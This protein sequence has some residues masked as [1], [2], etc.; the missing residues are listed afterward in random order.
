MKRHL[1]ARFA[2]LVICLLLLLPQ[3]LLFSSCSKAEENMIFAEKNDFSGKH[4][5]IMTGSIFDDIVDSAIDGVQYKN[6]MDI[7]GHIAALKKRDV[8]AIALDMPV[9]KLLVA[10]NPEFAIFPQVIADDQYGL[11][12]QKNSPLTQ[13]FTEAIQAFE[14]DGTIKALNDKWFSGDSEKMKIDW[15][16]YQLTNRKNGTLRYFYENT[17]MPMGYV[18]DGGKPAG[19]EV[20]LVLKI[21]DRLDMGVTFGSTT[22][23]ALINNLQA[24]KADVCSG[25]V[26]ITEERAKSVD[27]PVTHYKGGSVLVC[28]VEN[29]PPTDQAGVTNQSFF[30]GIANSIKGTFVTENRWKLIANGLLITLVITVFAGIIGTVLGFGL[31]LILRSRHKWLAKLGRGFCRL[32]TGVPSL[33]FLMIVYFVMFAASSLSPVV[34][35]ILA[36][37]VMFAVSVS[38]IFQTGIDAVDHG[39]WE[40]TAALGFGKTGSFAK[41]IMPQAMR[42]I[43][44]IYKGEFVSMLKLTSIVGYISI[45]DLTKAGDLIRSRTYEAFFP[46]IT[47]A[48]IYFII[49]WI[50]TCIIGRAEITFDPAKRKK[51]LL[52]GVVTDH[53]SQ[54]PAAHP[55]AINREPLIEIAH[56][57][58]EYELATPLTDVNTTVQRGDVI[59]IIGPSGTGKS[60]LLRC[61]NRLETPTSGQVKVFGQDIGDKKTDLN[62]VRQ[63]MGMVFQ[64]FN[65]FGHLTVIENLMLAPVCLKKMPRQE[66]Y[67]RGM[68]LLRMVGMAERAMQYPSALSGGQKQRVAIARALAMSPEVLLLDEPTSALDP[69]MVSEVLSVIKQLSAEHYTMVIVT[70]EMKFAKDVSNR[71]FYMDEGIIYE[72]GAPD[73][74]FENPL[75]EK[76][77]AFVK[78]LRSLN[79]EINSKDFDLYDLN[80]KLEEFA[81]RHFLTQAQL[82]NLQLVL[83]ELILNVILPHSQEISLRVGY[84]ETDGKLELKLTFGGDAL[85]PFALSDTD[86][87]AMMLV[88]KHAKDVAY[89]YNQGNSLAFT[90]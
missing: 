70:H 90:L 77:K 72:D 6:Y 39:Q 89:Q 55:A 44:P 37:S 13:P 87:L 11:V 9:A 19:Y 60:T 17:T 28:R 58:K 14:Q 4:V 73:Q 5:G 29:L 66:A 86:E 45:D 18:G 43:L 67:D 88:R 38:G 30:A 1:F 78:R 35:A 47:T 22:L 49:A 50:F 85:N 2:C 65:L 84:Y 63:R 61:M 40:A 36:F 74:V 64:S 41:V 79:Y 26:S 75:K 20:E 16:A 46:L 23:A 34:V 48:I 57:R 69:T 27:F 62:Q 53:V 82:F 8:D 76:T 33:V 24:D 3:L 83:E 56:L 21:A 54:T 71:V 42:H 68:E 15:S 25:C 32:I 81:H 59:S 12:L 31:C 10:Q 7:S 52:K 51:P 80:S